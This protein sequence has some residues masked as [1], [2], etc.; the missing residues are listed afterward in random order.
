VQSKVLRF[1]GRVEREQARSYGYIPFEVPGWARTVEVQYAYRGY[2]EGECTVDIGLFEP[3]P[4]SLIE[5]MERFR[6]W[7]GSNKKA[8][9]VSEC[10]AT[11]SYIPGPLKPGV[12]H[13]VLGFYKVPAGGCEYEVIVTITD[14]ARAEGCA[15]GVEPEK[16]RS[17][18]GWVRGD[19]HV[20]SVH[21]DG[22]STLREIAAKAREL[23][24]DFVAVTDHNT[25]SQIAEL[26]YRSAFV[27]GVLLLRGVEVTT[28][29]GHFNVFGVSFTPDFRFRSESEL[30]RVAQHLRE[31]N[32]VLSVDHPKPLGPDWEWGA[33]SFAHLVEVFHAIWEFN[34]Y[35]SLRKWDEQ[36]KR[37]V[38]LG[39][40]GGSD[41]HRVKG[42]GGV[43]QL[44]VPTTWVYV[45]E[46]SEKGLLEGLLRQRV[47]VSKSPEGPRAELA[48]RSAEGLVRMGGSAK[49]SRV[50]VLVSVT[51]AAG[52]RARLVS[53]RG[54]EAVWAVDQDSFAK[55]LELDARDLSFIRLDV[56]EEACDAW[57]PYHMENLL[58]ALTAP[59]FFER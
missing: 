5:G 26:G 10:S 44:G 21:S 40:I 36:L 46:L 50:E 27:E 47:F 28:Y 42:Y 23:G 16:A 20:H 57:D 17:K 4:L 34:N 7:S 25:H 15:A 56:L 29:K 8:F 33:M 31:R 51:G 22:D 45:D 9:Y 12:W 18:S 37:G 32:A 35:V 59:V 19:F 3:G 6:G 39:L 54:V 30:L 1:S 53:D 43:S 41:A 2:G 38:R 11:P 55:S 13:V 52:Q 49:A 58:S 48:V 14:E 24:L